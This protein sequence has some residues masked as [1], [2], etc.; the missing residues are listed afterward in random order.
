MKQNTAVISKR[1]VPDSELCLE[2]ISWMLL[3]CCSVKIPQQS[4]T[5]PDGKFDLKRQEGAYCWQERLLIL[6]LMGFIHDDVAPIEFLEVILLLDDHFIGCD[7]GIKWH[8]MTGHMVS[9]SCL[10]VMHWWSTIILHNKVS[11]YPRASLKFAVQEMRIITTK[12][13]GTEL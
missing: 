6:N 8:W 10:Q 13:L 12:S 9:L 5:W 3:R 7:A 2:A 11:T 1:A 4:K